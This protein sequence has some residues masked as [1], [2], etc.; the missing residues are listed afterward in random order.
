MKISNKELVSGLIDALNEDGLFENPFLEKGKFKVVLTQ[1]IAE[2]ENAIDILEDIVADTIDECV[3]NSINTA[4]DS[5]T[6]MDLIETLINKDG[7]IAY[8]LK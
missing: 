6:E 8:K 2:C 3:R 7:E 4:L 5:L 1:K